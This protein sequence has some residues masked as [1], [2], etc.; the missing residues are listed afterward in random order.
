MDCAFVN[1][2]RNFWYTQEFG[3]KVVISQGLEMRVDWA[4]EFF[5][6]KRIASSVAGCRDASLLLCFLTRIGSS[7]SFSDY[8][9]I[10]S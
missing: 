6:E 8:S 10:R 3:E 5:G 2:I 4:T 7:R 9:C 1:Y